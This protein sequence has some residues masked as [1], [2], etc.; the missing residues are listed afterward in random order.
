MLT[1][2]S[3]EFQYRNHAGL[4]RFRY[5]TSLSAVFCRGC[6]R[7]TLH[8]GGRSAGYFAAS[9]ESA[10]QTAR[11]GSGH[12]AVQ[13]PDARRGA[14]RSGRS[15]LRGRLQDPGAERCRAGES[16]RHRARAERQPV[17]WHHQLR[18]FSSQ[19][20]YPDSPVSGAEHGGAGSSGGSQYVVADDDAGGG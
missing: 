17:D 19:N 11:R 5:G 15:L 6:T 16:P 18:R 12:A 4:R 13:T 14:D 9:S 7:A 3:R 20:L 10:D 8:Q 1:R 2:F